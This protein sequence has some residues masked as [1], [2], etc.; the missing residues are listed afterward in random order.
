MSPTATQTVAS[1]TAMIGGCGE[2][3]VVAAPKRPAQ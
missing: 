3:R 2:E 1:A